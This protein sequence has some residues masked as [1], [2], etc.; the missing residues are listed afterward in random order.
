MRKS[1]I[2]DVIQIESLEPEPPWPGR[3]LTEL[4]VHTGKGDVMNLLNAE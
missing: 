3:F 4:T 2:N 1:G